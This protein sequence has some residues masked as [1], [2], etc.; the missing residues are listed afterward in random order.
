MFRGYRYDLSKEKKLAEYVKLTSVLTKFW[1]SCESRLF[2]KVFSRAQSGHNQTQ[3]ESTT[4]PVQ[5]YL[6]DGKF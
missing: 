2:E 5:G 3:K 6:R 4:T 1:Q